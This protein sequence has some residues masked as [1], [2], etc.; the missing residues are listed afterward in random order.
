MSVLVLAASLLSQAA[1]NGRRTFAERRQREAELFRQRGGP[2]PLSEYAEAEWL[3]RLIPDAQLRYEFA[4][5]WDRGNNTKPGGFPF[6]AHTLRQSRVLVGNTHRMRR[7]LRKL[8]NRECLR[9]LALGASVTA[10]WV[11]AAFVPWP[12]NLKRLLDARWPCDDP[13]RGHKVHCPSGAGTTSQWAVDTFELHVR[14]CSEYNRMLDRSFPG[15]YCLHDDDKIEYDMAIVEYGTMDKAF[16]LTSVRE[17]TEALA[18]KLL[19]LR[20]PE[21]LAVL[22]FSAMLVGAGLS[23]NLTQAVRKHD[24]GQIYVEAAYLPVLMHHELPLV[25]AAV[26][27]AGRRNG[28][29]PIAYWKPFRHLNIDNIHPRPPL[30]RFF[31]LVVFNYFAE[32]MD[33]PEGEA[34]GLPDVDLSLAYGGGRAPGLHNGTLRAPLLLSADRLRRVLSTPKIVM[35]TGRETARGSWSSPNHGWVHKA[36]NRRMDKY[37]LVASRPGARL[38]IPVTLRGQSWPVTVYYLYTYAN[39]SSAVAW[40]SRDPSERAGSCAAPL[41]LCQAW[42]CSCTEWRRLWAGVLNQIRSMM[43]NLG[44]KY[45]SSTGQSV[46]PSTLVQS[47]TDLAD[48]WGSQVCPGAY[49]SVMPAR[50]PQTRKRHAANNRQLE[51]ASRELQRR[52]RSRTAPLGGESWYWLNGKGSAVINFSSART[53]PMHSSFTGPAYLHICLANFDWPQQMQGEAGRFKVL[54]VSSG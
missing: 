47:A 22:W 11:T 17:W 27:L 26:P 9:V 50:M 45:N 29:R 54:A 14:S 7:V 38:V 42:G 30:S 44:D 2:A 31:A 3:R 23:R 34:Q 33:R 49:K 51:A 41:T 21:P 24:L 28:S 32:E 52:L 25:S 37:G 36:D 18:I 4:P 43:M 39:I 19:S 16:P 20:A 13:A 53:T 35:F 5:N 40:F 6:S 48:K 10:G 46:R 15:V 1:D 12:A 8:R